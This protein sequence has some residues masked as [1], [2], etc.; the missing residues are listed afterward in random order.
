MKV[1]EIDLFERELT[2]LKNQRQNPQLY[3]C[4]QTEID[5]QIELIKEAIRSYKKL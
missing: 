2:T 1:R 4:F 3:A 5:S